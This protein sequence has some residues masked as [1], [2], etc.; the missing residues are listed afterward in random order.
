MKF[1]TLSLLVCHAAAIWPAPQYYSYGSSVVWI[2]NTVDV[3]YNGQSVRWSPGIPYSELFSTAWKSQAENYTRAQV[4]FGLDHLSLPDSDSFDDQTVVQYAVKRMVLTIF[5]ENFIPWKLVPRN[6]LSQYE[7]APHNSKTYIKTIVI[8]QSG[9]DSASSFKPLAGQVDESYNLTVGIDGTTNI[10][11]VSH[12]GILRALETFTQLFYSQSQT[13]DVYSNLAPVQIIDKPIFPHRGLNLDVSRNYYP[14]TDI[15]RTIDA[16]AYNKF[17]RLHIH[18]TDS[19]SWPIDIP[20]LPELSQKG[21]YQTGLSY[22]PADF[23]GIQKYAVYRGVEVYIEIDMPGHT[24]AIGLSHPELI[25]AFDAQPWDTYCA[26]PPCGSL[27]LNSPAVSSFLQTL[28]ADVLPRVSPYSSYFHTGGDEVNAQAYTLDDTVMS[29]DTAVLQPLMQ[30]FVDRNHAQVRAAGLT[31]V[32]WE[33]MALQWNL[34][35]GSDVVVQTWISE[36]SLSEV[37]ALGHKALFGNYNFWVSDF[38]FP[39]KGR[40]SNITSILIAAKDNGLTSQTARHSTHS[41]HS[42]IIAHLLR[43]GD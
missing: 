38:L 29:N 11:A 35:L 18:M 41:T 6:Q 34:T 33:E 7:P 12:Q 37:T 2:E 1:L 17:N 19:Q 20:A 5:N 9:S 36:S 16:L 23:A 22:T 15:L 43:T 30:K 27:K 28:L 24:T 40:M 31:P 8:T 26:E 14:V 4:H 32:V 39:I 21:A 10:D 42:M 25:T 13:N 3:T